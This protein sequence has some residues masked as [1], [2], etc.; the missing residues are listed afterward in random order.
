MMARRNAIARRR[1][2]VTITK[3]LFWLVGLVLLGLALVPLLLL[4]GLFSGLGGGNG[5]PGGSGQGDGNG[6]KVI[7][8][9]HTAPQTQ[10][11]PAATQPKT[12]PT[13]RPKPPPNKSGRPLRIAI[14]DWDYFVAG[15]KVSLDQLA[16][17]IGKVPDGA[18]HAV[19]VTRH[20]TSRASAIQALKQLL[21]KDQVSAYWPE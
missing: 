12:Q 8:V 13:T 10:P 1:S 16:E 7:P 14:R 18:N 9:S 4:A 15:K 20:N 5:G 6:P 11:A 2:G 17:L 21:R 19:E 3:L